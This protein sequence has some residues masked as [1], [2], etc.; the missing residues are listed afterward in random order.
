MCNTLEN[1]TIDRKDADVLRKIGFVKKY[2]FLRELLMHQ[3]CIIWGWCIISRW[4][5]VFPLQF[6]SEFQI[7]DTSYNESIHLFTSS[8]PFSVFLDALERYKL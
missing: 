7:N 2:T 5:T 6:H 8:G 1:L 3:K 4:M